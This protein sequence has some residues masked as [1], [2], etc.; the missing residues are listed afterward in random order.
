MKNLEKFAAG[1]HHAVAL[2]SDGSVVAPSWEVLAFPCV[3]GSGRTHRGAQA[4]AQC[5]SI[6]PAKYPWICGS[7]GRCR[8]SVSGPPGPQ[9]PIQNSAIW[10]EHEVLPTGV[11]TARVPALIRQKEETP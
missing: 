10:M 4:P 8:S 7:V 5:R 9:T 11:S 1:T 6:R 2:Q 3:C